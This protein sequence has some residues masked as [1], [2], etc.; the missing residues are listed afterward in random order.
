MDATSFLDAEAPEV[1]LGRAIEAVASVDR[2][3]WS[4]AARS[5][6][7]ELLLEHRERLEATITALVGEWDAVGAWAEDGAR[8]PAAWLTSRAPVGSAEARALVRTARLVQT[9]PRTAK[10]LD[11][12]DITTRH[13]Q[14]AA[15]AARHLEDLY[16]EH[17]DVLLDA[18]HTT[19]VEDFRTVMAHWRDIADDIVGNEPPGARFERRHL[20]I[21]SMLDGWGRIDGALD[22]EAIAVLTQALDG[23]EPPDPVDGDR[24]ARTLAQRRAD[25]IVRLASG[26]ERPVVTIDAIV[27]VATLVG[28]LPDD[29]TTM[30]AE[31]RG[32]GAVDRDTLIRLACDAAVGRV[33]M[34]GESE[35]LDVGRR[36]R[37]VSPALRRA[38]EARDRGCVEPGCNAPADE[39]DAHHKV[40]WI[41]GGETSL[42]N[43][44]LRCRRCHRVQHDRDRR[45]RGPPGA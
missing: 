29:V 23:L 14:V 21:S 15:R 3:G 7:L 20:H 33:L 35:V 22:A 37:L 45:R 18:A 43:T 12:G 31:L 34:R 9:N 19:D 6:E 30:R 39:C 8:S 16:T 27:D 11:A 26:D 1:M 42:A 5:A 2:A 4:G 40:H 38:L 44:E 24:P 36:S 25:A 13:A 41:D 28:D 17:E 10:A 32:I